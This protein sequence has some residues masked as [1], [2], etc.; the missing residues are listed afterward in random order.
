MWLLIYSF[1]FFCFPQPDPQLEASAAI[2]SF[3]LS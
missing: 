2:V 1:S 3:L